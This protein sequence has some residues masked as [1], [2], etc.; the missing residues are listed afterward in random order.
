M[1]ESG[2]ERVRGRVS[3]KLNSARI[4]GIGEVMEGEASQGRE[5]IWRIWERGKFVVREMM[6]LGWEMKGVVQWEM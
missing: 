6:T 3:F 1:D 4:W 5:G 2:R